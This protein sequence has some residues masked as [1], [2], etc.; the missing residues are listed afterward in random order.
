VEAALSLSK[1]HK[2]PASFTAYPA[3][4]QF[5]KITFDSNRVLFANYD[6]VQAEI[7][8]IRNQEI[9]NPAQTP[10]I[11]LF[12]NY[13]GDGMSAVVFQ[14]IRESKALA[15][16]T[17][18]I[19]SVPSKKN[20]RDS[21]MG[22]VGTQADKLNESIKAMNEL[23][24]DM[25]ESDKGV[26]DAKDNIRKSLETERI[27]EEGILF[28][29]LA[30]QRKGLNYD[31]RKNTFTS[32]DKLDFATIKNFHDAELK[33]KPYTYCIVA[34]DKRVSDADLK[35]YGELI[36]PDMKQLFGY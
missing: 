32:L 23:L 18:A 2:T 25:P 26:T 3:Q 35:K 17:G 30:A 4:K 13:F 14:Q 36:K 27:T 12:N 10:Q 9:Y 28:D 21:F 34:S 20:E 5:T 24:E 15:Y 1:L 29:Y 31:E 8:W 7:Y 6:Q 11:E 33:G 16:S 19:Y 22:Y